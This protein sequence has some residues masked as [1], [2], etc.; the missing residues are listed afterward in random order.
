M[1]KVGE[2]IVIKYNNEANCCVTTKFKTGI[3]LAVI[4]L[5][6]LD[7]PADELADKLPI[8]LMPLFE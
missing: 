6:D 2:F 7:M 5:C 1:K 8:E 4:P 3:A